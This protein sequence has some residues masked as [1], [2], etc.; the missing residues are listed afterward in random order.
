MFHR[1]REL[2]AE[3]KQKLDLLG[4][5]MVEA[6]QARALA[7]ESFDANVLCLR[8]LGEI[9]YEIMPFVQSH[10]RQEAKYDTQKALARV[11]IF[12]KHAAKKCD[13]E[14][15]ALKK[16]WN[17]ILPPS[18]KLAYEASFAKDPWISNV[19]YHEDLFTTGIKTDISIGRYC[20][21]FRDHSSLILDSLSPK[22]LDPKRQVFANKIKMLSCQAD[23]QHVMSFSSL[24]L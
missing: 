14:C 19:Q 13:Q 7:P 24:K 8:K 18:R 3:E 16:I 12:K 5:K 10:L 6:V 20:I 21:Q 1:H 22:A 17:I 9:Y 11:S 23:Q 2:T 15:D 4:F